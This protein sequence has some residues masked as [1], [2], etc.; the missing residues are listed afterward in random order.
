[1]TRVF[2]DAM[3]ETLPVDL[4]TVAADLV[5]AEMVV[6]R[7]G[8]VADAAL[9]TARIPAMLPPGRSDGRLLVDGGLI[10][11]LPVGV[12]AAMNEGPVVAIE[13]G[14]RFE[15][16][17]EDD[18]SP[19]LPGVGETLMRSVLLGSAAMAE[20]VT[21]QADLLI[22]PEVSGLKMLAFHEIDKAVEIGRRAAEENLESIRALVEH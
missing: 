22:E 10:R 15:P 2:G 14:G 17:V 13:V 19:G 20:S 16:A 4:Y 21:A 3:I 8:R 18:G 9:S 5:G 12:M 7:R 1:M 6:Q 11:N